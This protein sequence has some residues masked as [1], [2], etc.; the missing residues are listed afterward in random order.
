MTQSK[1]RAKAT[2]R[3]YSQRLRPPRLAMSLVAVG[4]LLQLALRPSIAVPG[5]ARIAGVL[6]AITGFALMSRAVTLFDRRG[7]T[8]SFGA[9]PA[10]LVTDGLYRYSRNPMYFGLVIQLLGLAIAVGTWP[11]LVAPAGFV[12]AMDVWLIPEE[13][14]ALDAALGD[15]YRTY[16]RHVPRWV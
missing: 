11:M 16:K 5:P 6:L 13:E 4:V 9:P 12:V 15:A 2:R 1:R 10:T 3:P 8:H 14:R 7:T